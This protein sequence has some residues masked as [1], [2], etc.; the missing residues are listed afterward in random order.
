[1]LWRDLD[2]AVGDVVLGLDLRDDGV[3]AF[4]GKLPPGGS[5][6]FEA[7]DRIVVDV[8]GVEDARIEYNGQAIV[9]QG[10]QGVRRRLV[11]LDDAVA[12]R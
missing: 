10:R 2:A 3:A 7:Q 11:F 4:A 5:R 12:T 8:A 6:T 1:M 9:P